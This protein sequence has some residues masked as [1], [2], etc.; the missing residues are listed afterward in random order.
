MPAHHSVKLYTRAQIGCVAVEWCL[1]VTTKGGSPFREQ[2][3]AERD[4][5]VATGTES[6]WAITVLLISRA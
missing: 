3:G 6:A 4:I 1:I 5:V 2:V